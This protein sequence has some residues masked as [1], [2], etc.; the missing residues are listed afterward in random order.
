MPPDSIEQQVCDM[1]ARQGRFETL[2]VLG[3]GAM[4]SVVLVRDK[5]LSVRRAIKV[6][7][8]Q[9]I[10][11]RIIRSR[12]L[13]E[14]K[15]MARLECEAIVR[16][17]DVG[18]FD[19]W[20][21]IVMEYLDGGTLSEHLLTFGALPSRQAL[22]VILTVLDALAAA[23]EFTS[24]SGKPL[25]VIH[26]D[27]KPENILFT[28][29][30]KAKLA[31]FGIAQTR[32]RTL[33]LTGDA[34]TMGTLGY[35]SPEQKADAKT[36]DHRTDI[37]AVGVL[38]W[39]LLSWKTG[40]LEH[41]GANDFYLTVGMPGR[42]ALVPEELQ[43]L[44]IKATALDPNERFQSASEMAH[45]FREAL[46]TFPEPSEE[47]PIL[48]SAHQPEGILTFGGSG[49]SSLPRSAL[50]RAA[51][52]WSKGTGTIV[53]GSPSQ[54][55]QVSSGLEVVN[56]ARAGVRSSRFPV[57]PPVRETWGLREA[58]SGTILPDETIEET[59]TDLLSESKIGALEAELK[60]RSWRKIVA[61]G[62]VLLTLLGFLGLGTVG[63]LIW[64]NQSS[65]QADRVEKVVTEPVAESVVEAPEISVEVAPPE[66]IFAPV[67]TATQETPKV[68]QKP[69][70]K[71][72]D[73]P[74]EV[75]Q[76]ESSSSTIAKVN[77]VL[78]SPDDGV[79]LHLSGEG[80]T[81]QLSGAS[82]VVS[83]PLGTYQ[84]SADFDREG[85][86]PGTVVGTL[87]VEPG[88]TTITCRSQM[89]LCQST[90]LHR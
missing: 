67:A 57:E 2:K 22:G 21:F 6:I 79:I 23:H 18:E 65:K 8:P 16:I 83:V 77:L 68:T 51:E 84:V 90:T 53:P 55:G 64:V 40:E 3:K 42:M 85:V 13:D 4:G 63:T 82:R 88:L 47:I 1:L 9:F 29:S 76:Q 80:G 14:A 52:A 46:E 62:A 25:P 12:F 87:T 74:K 41:P 75:S 73:T 39:M 24:E 7:H 36:V 43:S 56:E 30:G 59:P 81:F 17:Y 5:R 60:K 33:G 70:S 15:I 10:R 50:D 44:I 27:V 38:L 72:K 61:L 35:M 66:P 20:M 11:S 31:D 89:S 54:V 71:S 34:S 58:D 86:T 28:R 37:H 78:K 32:E 45:A 69:V 26:R 49:L 48:G 19:D